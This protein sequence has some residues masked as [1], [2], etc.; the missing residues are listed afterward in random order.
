MC[1]YAYVVFNGSTIPLKSSKLDQPVSNSSKWDYESS[2]SKK[3][4]KKWLL[5]KWD[6][7]QF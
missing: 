5:V 3:I 2:S 1:Q 7:S 4:D 6:E